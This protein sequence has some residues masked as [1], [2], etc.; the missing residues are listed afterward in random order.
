MKTKT[1]FLLV[2]LIAYA[3]F[4]SPAFAVDENTSLYDTLNPPKP[5]PMQ[6]GNLGDSLNLPA[7]AV[8]KSN[9]CGAIK[10]FAS[11]VEC[12]RA[13]IIQPLIYLLFALALVYF[14][15]GVLQ[16]IRKGGDEDSQRE[17]RSMMI[18]GIIAIAVMVSV[19][20]LVNFLT[21]SFK[22]DNQTPIVPKIS[23]LK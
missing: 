18:F 14:L 16:Y 4:T 1:F 19:W 23:L 10:D 6:S 8:T 21:N 15:Y 22:L 5:T 12:A 13:G 9:S 3:V 17:A 20:G 11:A 2:I 7:S